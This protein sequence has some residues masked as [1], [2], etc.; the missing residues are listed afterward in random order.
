MNK[1]LNILFLCVAIILGFYLGDLVHTFYH[2]NAHK[3]IYENYGIKS[4]AEI[5]IF[6]GMTFPEKA[7]NTEDCKLSQS[8]TEI[9]GY[10]SIAFIY[11]LWFMFLIFMIYKEITR[12]KEDK[13]EEF[14]SN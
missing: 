13:N 12:K 11:N 2:E 3:Q 6:K 10:H 9:I 5:G 7:C 14:D 8:L 4:F 1:I